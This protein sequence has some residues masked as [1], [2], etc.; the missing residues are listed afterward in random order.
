L[1]ERGDGELSLQ[2]WGRQLLAQ[3][4]PIAALLDARH[5]DRTHSDALALQAAKLDN[6]D[7]TPSAQVLA[8]LREHG[9]SFAAFGLAQSERHAAYFR[10]HPPSAAEAAELDAMASASLAEQAS[11]EAAPR[12][13]F[14]DYVAAYRASNLCHSSGDCD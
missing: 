3:I 4:A 9:N 7:L 12:I 1:L 6:P 14:D 2:D 5:G 11:M 10:S 13:D 8:A